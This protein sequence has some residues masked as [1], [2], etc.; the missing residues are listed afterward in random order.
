MLA[1]S[2][3]SDSSTEEDSVQ[4][5]SELLDPPAKLSVSSI[6]G[7]RSVKMELS[8]AELTPVLHLVINVTG[9]PEDAHD[10]PGSVEELSTNASELEESE[11]D[12]LDECSLDGSRAEHCSTDE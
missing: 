7:N 4:D 8:G 11:I 10:S 1:D 12:R 5:T 6:E 9:V 2:F 3:R